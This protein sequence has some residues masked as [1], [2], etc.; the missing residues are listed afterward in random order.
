MFESFLP[1]LNSDV[2]H[3]PDLS[4]A[5]FGFLSKSAEFSIESIY[6]LESSLFEKLLFLLC[7]AVHGSFGL[8]QTKLAF[9][10]IHKICQESKKLRGIKD[11][12][13]ALAVSRMLIQV[14]LVEA[15]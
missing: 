4:H 1:L 10:T 8:Q 3:L 15:I 5:Y 2:L 6:A 13:F 7:E 12:P 14:S 11:G 9:D